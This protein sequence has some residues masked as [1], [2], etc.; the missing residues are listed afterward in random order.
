M[1]GVIDH[2]TGNILGEFTKRESAL[3]LWQE[4]V[5]GDSRAADHVQVEESRKPRR[6]SGKFRSARS[7]AIQA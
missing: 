5:D 6:Q 3:A 4:I 2:T 1:W 7:A